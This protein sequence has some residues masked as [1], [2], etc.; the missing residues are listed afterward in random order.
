ME[1]KLEMCTYG[2]VAL[3]GAVTLQHQH[4]AV[5][6]DGCMRR[7]NNRSPE[8]VRQTKRPGSAIAFFWNGLTMVSDSSSTLS[9]MRWQE[10]H[11]GFLFWLYWCA[12]DISH[13]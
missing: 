3:K 1:I 2:H 9:H 10:S 12:A 13:V 5:L 6:F 4:K 8:V 7:L 11:K